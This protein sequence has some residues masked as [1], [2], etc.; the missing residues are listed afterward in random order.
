MS[1]NYDQLTVTADIDDFKSIL[2]ANRRIGALDFMT[3]V[4]TYVSKQTN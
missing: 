4:G 3:S 2:L 1:I